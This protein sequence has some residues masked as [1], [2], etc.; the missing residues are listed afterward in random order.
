VLYGEAWEILQVYAPDALPL[1]VNR[2]QRWPDERAAREIIRV[3]DRN[4][5]GFQR[6]DIPEAVDMLQAVRAAIIKRAAIV[7]AGFDA[8]N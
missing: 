5:P 1:F 4:I 3:I 2:W 8:F 6:L 7:E